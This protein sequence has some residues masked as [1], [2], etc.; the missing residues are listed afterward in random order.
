MPKDF[1]YKNEIIKKT[2]ELKIKEIKKIN[3]TEDLVGEITEK[4]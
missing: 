3:E 2:Q 4:E 1:P